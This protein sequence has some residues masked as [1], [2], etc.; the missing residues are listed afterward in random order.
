[1]FQVCSLFWFY[2]IFQATDTLAI[3]LVIGAAVFAF[4]PLKHLMML[5][6]METFTREM[7]LRKLSSDRLIRRLKEW[8]IRIPAAPVQLI[9]TE[10][11]KRK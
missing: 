9:V 3:F 11:K 6:F 5:V 7:P 1:M 2:F 8:W 10:E 4:M